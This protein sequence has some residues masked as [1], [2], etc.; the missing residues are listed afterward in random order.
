MTQAYSE[1]NP[2]VPNRSPSRTFDPPITSS[3][4]A[5]HFFMYG[6]LQFGF[7][8]VFFVGVVI[9]FWCHKQLKDCFCSAHQLPGR[10]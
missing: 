5:R 4:A 1:K 2:S 6:D 9:A 7:S 8:Q 3:D 10:L